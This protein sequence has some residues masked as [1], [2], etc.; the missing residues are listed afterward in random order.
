LAGL[1]LLG[2]AQPGAR[3][4]L[5]MAAALPTALA[6]VTFG[7]RGGVVGGCGTLALFAVWAAT[8][9]RDVDVA[10]WVGAA[11][12]LAMGVLLG[13]AMDDLDTSE[14]RARCAEATA[15]AAEEVA[16]RHRAATEIND[17]IVQEVAVAKW[18]LESGRVEQAVSILDEAVGAG[19]R[20]VSELLAR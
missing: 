11:A 14:A 9:G 16:A 2:A 5:G 13:G 15:A 7:R 17:R 18:A 10:G 8:G 20:L 4:P 19:Q 3:E 12:L 6:A 1:A